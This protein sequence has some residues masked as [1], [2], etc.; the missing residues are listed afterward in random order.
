[1]KADIILYD[2]RHLL[3]RTSDAFGMLSVEIGGEDVGTGGVY[4]FLSV[5]LRIHQRYGGRA[6][7]AWEGTNNF[8]KQLYPEYKRKEEPDQDRLEFI[9]DLAEQEV[10][11]KAI[12]RA[13]GVEQYSGVGCEADDVLGRMATTLAAL[14]HH[15][16]I[17][18]GDSDLRQLVNDQITVVAPGRKGKDTIYDAEAV[19]AKHG[20]KPG[21][22]ADLKAL[23]GDSSDNIPGIRG[24]GDKTAA[25]LIAA[26]GDV[27][28][29]IRGAQGAPEDWQG[30]A[31]FQQAI[32]DQADDI[33]LYKELTT[34]RTDAGLKLIKPSRSQ[35]RVVRHL[36]A[37][38]FRSLV[39]PAEL[40]GL[41]RMAG[42]R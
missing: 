19:E 42:G 17:Y 21:H 6:I 29:I 9:N 38:K 7:V 8:R 33:R 37:Y 14:G 22:L 39:A 12:L 24:I 36:M 40:N 32:A 13:M 5:A 35:R 10:R 25:K 41:M 27:E 16:V 15:V 34:I 3:W 1:M 31:R 26:Y 30:A 20:V 28:G 23:A 18:T 11:L 2:G 4:G